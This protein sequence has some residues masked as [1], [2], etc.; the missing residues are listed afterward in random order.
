MLVSQ[1][2][3]LIILASFSLL[4]CA[5]CG[6]W[7]SLISD[8]L[9]SLYYLT[10]FSVVCS[11]SSQFVLCSQSIQ[12]MLCVDIYYFILCVTILVGRLYFRLK[13]KRNKTNKLE[14]SK[15]TNQ[16][17]LSSPPYPTK[18]SIKLSMD[19]SQGINPFSN[20]SDDQ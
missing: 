15:Q 1:F 8:L 13:G 7:I 9:L 12:F 4:L 14:R 10:L 18:V 3:A 20:K 19:H 16:A 11:C 2:N 5:I 17:T 6:Y